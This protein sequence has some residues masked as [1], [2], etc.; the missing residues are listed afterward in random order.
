MHNHHPHPKFSIITVTYN[1]AKVLE[2]TI[3]SIVTQ[4]YKNLEYII[5][6][7]GSTDETLDIIHKYQ[8]HITTVISEPDQGLYDA[9]NKGIKLATGDYLCFLNAGDGLH[10]DDTLL[11]MVH[12]INGTA[13]PGVLYGEFKSLTFIIGSLLEGSLCGVWRNNPSD[14][15]SGATSMNFCISANGIPISI[16]SSQG[17]NPPW[18]TAPNNVPPSSQ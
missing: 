8:E 2:D 11:Q 3:Q 9:M 15:S 6:D 12:S 18:R 16:S 13:L 7:G 10:E 17:M 4:T 1:A 14:S 5:V